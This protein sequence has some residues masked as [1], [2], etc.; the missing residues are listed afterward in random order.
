MVIQALTNL[1]IPVHVL[2]G[3][4]RLNPERKMH[5]NVGQL[6]FPFVR[7]PFPT[8]LSPFWTRFPDQVVASDHMVDPRCDTQ[9]WHRRVVR[10][11]VRFV[12]SAVVGKHLR[13]VPGIA[14]NSVI[15]L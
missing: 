10:R 13:P 12:L 11:T 14:G 7:R 3:P 4:M 6:A 2:F 8:C 5:W 1:G 9:E 15:I